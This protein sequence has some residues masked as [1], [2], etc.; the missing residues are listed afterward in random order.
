MT[1]YHKLHHQREMVGAATLILTAVARLKTRF[2]YESALNRK[3][4]G[5]L[6]AHRMVELAQTVYDIAQEISSHALALKTAA[7][8]E[9]Q[10]LE[11]PN[12]LEEND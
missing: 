4:L 11:T 1:D 12:Q 7:E 10:R 5:F 8:A 6:P 3:R 2:S 9:M